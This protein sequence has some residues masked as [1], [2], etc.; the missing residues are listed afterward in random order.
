MSLDDRPIFMIGYRGTGK[1]TV[2]R[3]LAELL[4]FDCV[5]ADDL[6]EERAGKSI[7]AIFADD[8]E[9]A[10]RDLESQVVRELAAR[11]RTVVALGGGA[12]L[13]EGNRIAIK[14]AGPVVWLIASVDS[15][16]KRLAADETTAGRRPNLTAMGG[17]AEIESLLAQ[18]TPVYRDCA[19]L[20]VDTEGKTAAQVADEIKAALM[21]S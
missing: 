17:R 2:A 3:A 16:A 11:L 10:F 8:G 12:V 15:I 18:R 21:R 4:G 19:T 7:A 20:V 9:A 5:D 1:S 14:A 6:I 13:R